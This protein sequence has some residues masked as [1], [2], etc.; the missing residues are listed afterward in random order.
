MVNRCRCCKG[1]CRKQA[2][3]CDDCSAELIERARKEG[4]WPC[5]VCG[6][7]TSML[8]P[9]CFSTAGLC[10]VCARLQNSVRGE[11]PLDGMPAAF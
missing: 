1:H 10:W 11:R 4:E 2:D 8:S 6:A 5:E 7:M 9:R 3:L